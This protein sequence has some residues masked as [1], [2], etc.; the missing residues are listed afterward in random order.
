MH[1]PQADGEITKAR[2]EW[3]YE[4]GSEVVFM[5]SM[6]S[7]VRSRFSLKNEGDR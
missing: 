2:G 1:Y 7:A 4:E 6:G 3:V 5:S